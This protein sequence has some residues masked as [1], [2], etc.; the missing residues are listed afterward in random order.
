MMFKSRF[1][2]ILLMSVSIA[3]V[4]ETLCIPI[5]QQQIKNKDSLLNGVQSGVIKA[6]SFIGDQYS[7]VK[8]FVSKNV[9]KVKTAVKRFRDA[10]AE[11]KRLRDDVRA[12]ARRQKV[13]INHSSCTLRVPMCSLLSY[14]DHLHS[15]GRRP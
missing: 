4:S 9:E 13:S 7:L 1:R 12:P 3:L 2:A 14:P 10:K 6:R 15:I 5:K 11:V 8:D